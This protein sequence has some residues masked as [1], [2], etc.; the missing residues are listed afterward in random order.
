[1]CHSALLLV[2]SAA[3]VVFSQTI[4]AHMIPAVPSAVQ[5]SFPSTPPGR[6]TVIG[7]RIEKVDCVQDQIRL[8]VSGARAI[9]ISFDERTQVY[10][11]GTKISVLHLHPADHASIETTL[12]GTAIFAVR[13]HIL[14]NP[15]NGRIRGQVISYEPRLGDLTL[16]VDGSS[17]VVLVSVTD[18][19]TGT[20]G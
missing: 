15:T 5:P 3:T 6:T 16:R 12:D 17:H 9:T 13:I 2:L 11:D 14:T 18:T 8:K 7:G 1:M 19:P 10:Q 4:P 20:G